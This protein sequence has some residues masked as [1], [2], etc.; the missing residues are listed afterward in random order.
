RLSK[1]RTLI[2]LNRRRLNP[3]WGISGSSDDG[4]ALFQSVLDRLHRGLLVPAPSKVWAGN[5][6]GRTCIVCTQTIFPDQV[7]NG[8]AINVAR[9]VI[10]LW[11][12]VSCFNIW[13]RASAMYV[14]RHPTSTDS[15]L[16]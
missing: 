11:A 8:I 16:A 13:R 12:H 14:Q 10:R 7:E 15:H 3:W 6:T 4:I 9:V 5:G 2:I 1:T